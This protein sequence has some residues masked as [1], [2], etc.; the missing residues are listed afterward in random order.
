MSAAFLFLLPLLFHDDG[1]A[2]GDDGDVRMVDAFGFEDIARHDERLVDVFGVFDMHVLNHLL[3]GFCDHDDGVLE[4]HAQENLG[5]PLVKDG[6]IPLAGENFIH[7]LLEVR[8]VFECLI[9]VFA[10]VA[11]RAS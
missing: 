6:L 8:G 9:E 7:G 1:D 5:F 4:Q 11:V 10:A 2:V 3:R